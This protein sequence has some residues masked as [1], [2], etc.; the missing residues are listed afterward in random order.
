MHV[1]ATL[2]PALHR[3]VLVH[4]DE[5]PCRVFLPRIDKVG[6]ELATEIGVHFD[7][8]WGEDGQLTLESLSVAFADRLHCKTR[9]QRAIPGLLRATY[10]NNKK[11]KS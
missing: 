3:S 5:P 2:R 7:I 1:R 8:C 9:A 6:L 4:L 10:Q 11:T